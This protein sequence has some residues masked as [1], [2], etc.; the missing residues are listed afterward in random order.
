MNVC[1]FNETKGWSNWPASFWVP[2]GLQGIASKITRGTDAKEIVRSQHFSSKQSET[3][4]KF[5]SKSESLFLFL[6]HTKGN[7]WVR[8]NIIPKLPLEVNTKQF[9]IRN[10]HGKIYVSWLEMHR[11]ARPPLWKAVKICAFVVVRGYFF[12]FFGVCM[13]RISLHEIW[14]KVK[15]IRG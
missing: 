3:T 10:T 5:I 15:W 1:S 8:G 6:C 11:S 4:M 13:R 2:Y 7:S 14:G 12:S 9:E